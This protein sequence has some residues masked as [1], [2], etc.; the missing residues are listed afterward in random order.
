MILFPGYCQ[1]T[2]APPGIS[3]RGALFIKKAQDSHQK[4]KWLTAWIN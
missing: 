1:T 4:I 3:G 2:G